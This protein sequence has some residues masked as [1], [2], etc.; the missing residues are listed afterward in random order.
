MALVNSTITFEGAGRELLD[1]TVTKTID[2]ID[3]LPEH[4]QY[5]KKLGFSDISLVS[6]DQKFG[7]LARGGGLRPITETGK[8]NLRSVTGLPRK[9]VYQ[10]EFGDEF[11]MSYMFTQWMKNSKTVKG[12]SD[13][14]QAELV[15]IPKQIQDLMTAY[16]IVRAEE[17]V[18]VLAKGFSVSSSEGPGAGTARGGLPLFSA[19][20][21]TGS[22]LVSGAVYTNVTTGVNQ[23][24]ASLDKMKTMKDE[25]GKK[26]KQPKV[27]TLAVS[28]ERK[29]FWSQVLNYKAPS[30]AIGT[31]QGVMNQF[32]FDG[33]MVELTDIDLLGD[34]GSDGAVIGN[35]DNAFLLNLEYLNTNE[36]FVTYT[37]YTPHLK[38]FEDQDTDE[39]V[40]GIRAAV[41]VDHV[42][43][44]LGCVGI[45]GA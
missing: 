42:Y 28:R 9:S 36:S 2:T 32:N 21:V 17:I 10:R 1:A 20:H 6:P 8:R 34:T 35:T 26:I 31:N 19:S 44:E 14:I 7:K 18:K 25:N 4:N 41:G 40:T 13:S 45:V 43:A 24:Q 38:T 33:N 3:S 27:Y 23:L 15:S 11:R 16:D 29:T 12:S 39:L 5:A 22:N 37:L 30:S